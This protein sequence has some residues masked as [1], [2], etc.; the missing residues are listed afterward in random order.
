M[1]NCANLDFNPTTSGNS[2]YNPNSATV[3]VK[4][5]G[6]IRGLSIAVTAISSR[7]ARKEPVFVRPALFNHAADTADSGYNRFTLAMP[8]SLPNLSVAQP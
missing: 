4:A 3:N 6:W 1:V 8:L 5:V 7:L 2:S